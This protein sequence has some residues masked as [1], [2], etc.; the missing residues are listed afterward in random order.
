MVNLTQSKTVS[1]R[2]EDEQFEFSI[3]S[4]KI[5]TARNLQNKLFRNK[6]VAS[7]VGEKLL[8]QTCHFSHPRIKGSVVS[9]ILGHILRTLLPMG[10]NPFPLLLVLCGT[11]ILLVEDTI[12]L[13]PHI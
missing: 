6:L 7:T 9:F 8:L 2:R 10:T 3:I 12:L 1:L 5:S 13:V 4:S 11:R